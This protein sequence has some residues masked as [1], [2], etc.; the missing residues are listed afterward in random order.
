MASII[1]QSNG[2]RTIQFHLGDGKRR[3]LRLGQVSRRDAESVRLRV[4]ELVSAHLLGQPLEPDTIAW[5]KRL[6][7]DMH[8]KLEAVG[9]VKPR[10]AAKLLPFVD[11]YIKQRADVKQSTRLVYQQ[12]R[13]Y[14]GEHFPADKLLRDVTPGDADAFLLKLKADGLRENT[15][16]RRCGVVKQFMRAAVRRRLI[17]ANPFDGIPCTV[18]GNEERQYFVT[19]EE[20]YKVLDACPDSQW[21]LI[22]ALA[23]FGGL[24][25]PSEVVR[26]KWSDVNWDGGWFTVHSPKT[27]HHEGKATRRVPIFGE[28]LPYLRESWEQAEPGEDRIITRYPVNVGNLG[29][30]LARIVEHA[31][32]KPWPKLFQN[33]RSTRQ[34][35]LSDI[36]PTWKVCEWM[37]NTRQVA[38][39]HYLKMRDEDYKKAVQIPVQQVQL[40]GGKGLQRAASSEMAVSVTAGAD[41][42]LQFVAGDC[43]NLQI[44]KWAVQDLNL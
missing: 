11:A 25:C 20:A 5:V 39:E 7:D 43:E 27:E 31:G 41:R 38:V 15:V 2:R 12:T 33:L 13:R 23:R 29:T 40:Q 37:G 32:L 9:L 6:S 21:R 3:S 4:H 42:D 17:E 44:V 30:Q 34:T 28:L 10:E 19:M 26:L 8:A 18:G 16:R 24:R 14:L 35:E 22:F 1:E 36:H